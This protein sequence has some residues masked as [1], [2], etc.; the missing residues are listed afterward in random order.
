MKKQLKSLSALLSLCL[1]PLMFL[2][3]S[4]DEEK[5]PAFRE[6]VGEGGVL[7]DNINI[8]LVFVEGGSFMMGDMNGNADEKPLR[9]VIVVLF[10]IGKY[11]VTQG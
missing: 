9:N 6:P 1:V 7:L 10:E 3:F 2:L 11:E 4:C 8:P 5:Y